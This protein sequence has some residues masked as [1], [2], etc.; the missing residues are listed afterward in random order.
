VLQI[1]YKGLLS[2]DVMGNEV[3][4][5]HSAHARSILTLSHPPV[6]DASKSGDIAW[7][8]CQYLTAASS[9]SRRRALH[10]MPPMRGLYH[11]S[12]YLPNVH[13]RMQLPSC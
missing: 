4:S 6:K 3:R 12:A 9:T 5:Q 10:I 11:T 1:D 8:I 13:A 2:E 7:G